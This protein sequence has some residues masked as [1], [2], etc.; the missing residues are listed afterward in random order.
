MPQRLMAFFIILLLGI[1]PFLAITNPPDDDGDAVEKVE[2]LDGIE[3]AHD[4]GEGPFII[5]TSAYW[6]SRPELAVSIAAEGNVRP[7]AMELARNFISG[8]LTAAGGTA[9][10]SRWDALLRSFPDGHAPTLHLEP[11]GQQQANITVVLTDEDHPEGKM[12][13][14]RL[15]AVKGIRHILS[16]E[17]YIYSANS[18]GTGHARARAS[19]EMGHALGLSHSTNPESIM[20]SV[21]ELRDGSVVN[22][23]GSCEE[24]GMA[25]LY[26]EPRIGS[27]D[28]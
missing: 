8:N 5:N 27:A 26:V 25:M 16:T 14:T 9:A 15:Y 1:V 10:T 22:H 12:G 21:I 6:D 17:V 3:D 7:E 4:A 2:F 11:G 18:A 28:C 19:H 13:K 23:M 20:V 24:S